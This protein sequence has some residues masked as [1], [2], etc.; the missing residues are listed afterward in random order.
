MT[1]IATFLV[2]DQVAQAGLGKLAYV[3]LYNGEI[4][5]P[6]IPF[7][8]QQLYFVV[9]FRTAIGDPPTKFKIRIERPGFPDLEVDHSSRL[10]SLPSIGPDSRFFQAQAVVQIAPMEFINT[11]TIRVFVEDEI[12]DN[13][14][15]GLRVKTGVHPELSAPQISHLTQLVAAHY[16]RLADSENRVREVSAVKLL[17]ATAAFLK[18][19]GINLVL[20][21]PEQGLNISLDDKRIQVFFPKPLSTVPKITISPSERYSSAIVESVDRIG[22]VA[23]FEPTAPSDSLFDYAI[24]EDAV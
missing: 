6:A 13:Y 20:P 9:S 3:G 16:E 23:A 4:L 5:L 21:N 12:G 1:R 2:C 10:V 8:L 15:G 14:A 17:N 7:T 19:A 22:F 24:N 18:S 11:E